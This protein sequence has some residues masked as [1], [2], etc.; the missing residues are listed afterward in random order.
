MDVLDQIYEHPRVSIAAGV[1]ASW[2][3]YLAALAVYRL[4]FSP[5]SRFPG[6]KLAATTLV[7]KLWHQG[8]GNAVHWITEQHRRYGPIVRVGPTEVS[9][10]DAQAYQDIYGFRAPGK[11]PVDKDPGFY[12][13]ASLE[14]RSIINNP[15]ADHART[16]RIFS[17][18]FSDRALKEQEPILMQS[19]DLLGQKMQESVGANAKVD[20]VKMMNFTFF[21]IMGTPFGCVDLC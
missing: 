5:L 11:P 1:F 21:D 14:T 20:I 16:R 10:I 13:F 12:D 8:R 2:I 3:I 6:P 15:D 7:V 17:N 19:I 4:F 9:F 18:A